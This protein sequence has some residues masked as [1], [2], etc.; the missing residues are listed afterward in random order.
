MC[1]TLPRASRAGCEDLKANLFR[2]QKKPR[3]HAN[4][5]CFKPL[6]QALRSV[7]MFLFSTTQLCVFTVQNHM[8]LNDY[9]LTAGLDIWDGVWDTSLVPRFPDQHWNL[10]HSSS[11]FTRILLLSCKRDLRTTPCTWEV[12]WRSRWVTLCE[13]CSSSVLYECCAQA[14]VYLRSHPRHGQEQGVCNLRI[15]FL[16]MTAHDQ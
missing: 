16:H 14:S 3:T 7:I 5:G 6:G 10:L 13:C 15:C 4:F 12:T 8:N 9:T 1:T 2:F 11:S